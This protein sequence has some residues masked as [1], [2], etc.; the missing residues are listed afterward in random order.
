MIAVFVGVA[1]VVSVFV[2]P[3]SFWLMERRIERLNSWAER[4][5]EQVNMEIAKTRYELDKLKKELEATE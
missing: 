3:Y 5:L 4:R 1:F 2:L